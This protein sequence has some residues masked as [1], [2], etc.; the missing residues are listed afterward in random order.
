MRAARR[1]TNDRPVMRDH[2]LRDLAFRA[3]GRLFAQMAG[4]AMHRHKD[5]GAGQLIHPRQILPARMARYMDRFIARR[6]HADATPDQKVLY[7]TDGFFIARNFA[8]RKH[9]RITRIKLHGRMIT[10]GNASHRRPRFALRPGTDQQGLILR[11]HPRVFISQKVRIR[12]QIANR[13]CGL[14]HTVQ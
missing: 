1:Q 10:L 4:F 9:N 7:I 12:R 11:A 5:F 8:C 3:K 14:G 13:A 6:N 2:L